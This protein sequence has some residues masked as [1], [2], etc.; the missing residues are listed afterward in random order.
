MK[1]VETIELLGKVDSITKE[2]KP[3]KGQQ[4]L[5]EVKVGPEAKIGAHVLRLVTSAVLPSKR[6]EKF[7][8][9]GRFSE[10]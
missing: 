5:V 10:V 8:H 6:H 3:K 2:R 9:H 1:S 4:V 7:L